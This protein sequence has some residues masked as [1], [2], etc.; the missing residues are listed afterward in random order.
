MVEA[1]KAIIGINWNNMTII[2]L[3]KI[4]VFLKIFF[5]FVDWVKKRYRIK[6]GKDLDKDVMES[7]ITRLEKHDK[8]QYDKIMEI[9]NGINDIQKTI[10]HCELERKAE[11]VATLRNQLYGLH[12]IFT[13]QGYI[14]SSG[15]RT[16][17]E[18]GAIYEKAGGDDIY[19]EKLYPEI[20]ALK[21][22]D[23]PSLKNKNDK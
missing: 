6:T 20:M 23:N 14:D 4:A 10:S 19:H 12:S 17:T 21:I 5:E 13:A 9:I 15:L 7:R 2:D 8:W 1:A 18:L 11:T 22:K 3:V 16:F